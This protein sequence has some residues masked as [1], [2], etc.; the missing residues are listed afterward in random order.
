[1]DI[2]IR[3]NFDFFKKEKFVYH[4]IQRD[5]S[6]KYNDFY[7]G[8]KTSKTKSPSVILAIKLLDIEIN[9]DKIEF[10]LKLKT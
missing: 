6:K 5:H 10:L 8:N 4:L 2:T 3:Y 9:D 1:V 7:L